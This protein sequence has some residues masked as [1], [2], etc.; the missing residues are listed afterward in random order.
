MFVPRTPRV[1]GIILCGA[2]LFV[3]Q[4]LCYRSAPHDASS[5]ASILFFGFPVVFY[6]L[7]NLWIDEGRERERADQERRRSPPEAPPS[8]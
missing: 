3:P 2:L 8:Q 7:A 5:V 4:M 6:V 1:I